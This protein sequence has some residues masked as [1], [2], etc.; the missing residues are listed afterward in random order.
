M[1]PIRRSHRWPAGERGRGLRRP[2]GDRRGGGVAVA[3]PREPRHVHRRAR[4]G[5]RRRAHR[6]TPVTV[7]GRL[8]VAGLLCA[9]LT[10]CGGGGDAGLPDF[11]P[12]PK[13]SDSP[14]ALPTPT[15]TASFGQDKPVEAYRGFMQA[16]QIAVG[17]ANPDYPGLAK[18]GQGGALEYWRGRA[19]ELKKSNHV[20][21]GPL[22][23]RPALDEMLSS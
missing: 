18:Y 12:A 15:P 3:G 16:V 11:Q 5:V 13:T 1:D 9:L 20:I 22:I 21:L 23:S 19:E 8:A 7:R 4:A 10:G 2:P 14:G 6:R 17:T